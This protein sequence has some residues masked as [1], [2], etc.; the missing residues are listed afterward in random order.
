[1]IV[2]FKARSTE[3][4]SA[5]IFSGRVIIVL[6]PDLKEIISD[7]PTSDNSDKGK[8][9]FHSRNKGQTNTTNKQQLGNSV[10][11]PNTINRRENQERKRRDIRVPTGRLD[12]G[13]TGLDAP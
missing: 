2:A 1:M 7:G 10:S 5:D 6:Y 11:S 9:T 8:P 4:F 13:I 3:T 12:Q